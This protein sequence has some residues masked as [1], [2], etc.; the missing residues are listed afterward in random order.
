MITSNLSLLFFRLNKPNSFSFLLISSVSFPVFCNPFG[1]LLLDP[2][3]VSRELFLSYI[4]TLPLGVCT[5]LPNFVSSEGLWGCIYSHH[6]DH[7]KRYWTGSSP[8]LTPKELFVTDC[9][10]EFEPWPPFEH[11]SLAAAISQS[12]S[13]TFQ[14][15][16]FSILACILLSSIDLSRPSLCEVVLLT[17]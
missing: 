7:F 13:K 1:V 15:N 11:N 12:T 17:C 2:V 10:S 8:V 6:P 3:S 9:R 4:V 14:M 5:C 16:S